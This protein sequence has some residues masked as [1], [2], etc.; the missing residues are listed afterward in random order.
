MG[1]NIKY[2]LKYDGSDNDLEWLIWYTGWTKETARH[3]L[4]QWAANNL[5][6]QTVRGVPLPA[7][8]KDVS[9]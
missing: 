3:A 6:H 9:R 1:M 2:K 5:I 7:G 8:D 4:R